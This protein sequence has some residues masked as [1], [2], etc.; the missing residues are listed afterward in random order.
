MYYMKPK[1]KKTG[2]T[3]KRRTNRRKRK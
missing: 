3:P 2:N 1:K